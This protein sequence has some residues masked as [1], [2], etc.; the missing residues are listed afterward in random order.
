MLTTMGILN[1]AF[2]CFG[3]LCGLMGIGAYAVIFQW[4][5][6]RRRRAVR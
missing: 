6:K 1:I 5:N 4:D 3:L 2:G